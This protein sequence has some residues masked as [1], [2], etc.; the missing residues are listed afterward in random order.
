MPLTCISR[1]HHCRHALRS[2]TRGVPK[3]QLT[4]VKRMMTWSW[5]L[6]E[7]KSQAPP[8]ISL[9]TFHW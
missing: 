3:P 1:T 2:Q 6:M 4:Q 7:E 8:H 5:L 9:P